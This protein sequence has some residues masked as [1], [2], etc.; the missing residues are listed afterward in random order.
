MGCSVEIPALQLALVET[1]AAATSAAKKPLIVVV[2]SGGFLDLTP[3]K[4]DPRLNAI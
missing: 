4:L 3:W 2:M 1:V